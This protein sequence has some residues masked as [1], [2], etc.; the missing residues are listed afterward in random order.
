MSTDDNN[1]DL[2]LGGTVESSLL[3]KLKELYEDGD[4]DDDVL[5]TLNLWMEDVKQLP[6]YRELLWAEGEGSNRDCTNFFLYTEDRTNCII[7]GV[8]FARKW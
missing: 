8:K 6:F 2:K 4:E 1:G 5:S 3:A 7:G